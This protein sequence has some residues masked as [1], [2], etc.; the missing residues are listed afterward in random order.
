M[1]VGKLL[2]LQLV[3]EEPAIC[4]EVLYVFSLADGREVTT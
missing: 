3:E 4:A 1:G 2:Q